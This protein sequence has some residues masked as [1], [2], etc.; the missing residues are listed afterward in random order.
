MKNRIAN[1][2]SR[3]DDDI[4]AGA[5][6]P[7]LDPE[8]GTAEAFYTSGYRAGWDDGW[9]EKN[10]KMGCGFLIIAALLTLCSFIGGYVL[11][12]LT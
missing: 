9:A 12:K 10:T 1:C 2:R 4:D 7:L 5:W 8:E 6:N 11:G 3:D